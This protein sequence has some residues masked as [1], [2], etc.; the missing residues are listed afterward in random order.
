MSVSHGPAAGLPAGYATW[1][2]GASLLR[3]HSPLSSPNWYGPAIGATG[4][5]RFDLPTPR[6][7]TDPGV[8]YVAASLTGVLHERV[9]RGVNQPVVSRRTMS[10]QHAV[11]D[12]ASTRDLVLIDLVAGLSVHRLQLHD[13]T[14]PPVVLP[15][16]S[17]PY[18]ATQGLVGSWAA[19]NARRG[20]P[21]PGGRVDG[22]LY[23]SRFGANEYCLAI[24]DVA[25]PFVSWRTS[26]LLG[27][28]AQL[29][30][31]C[32]ALGVIVV[33]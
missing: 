17:L 10:A 9:F 11:C 22:I 33:P 31:A 1:A 8:C 26:Q 15:P 2:S 24:W 7:A 21:V 28:H 4:T 23:V 25:A 12:V 18:P 14:A 5:N 20:F 3:G 6:A 19:T 13:I 27:A 30:T 32:G 16:G 29:A